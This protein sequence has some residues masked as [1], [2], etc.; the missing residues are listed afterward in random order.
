MSSL[1]AFEIS[2]PGKVILHGEHSVVYGKPAIAGP[3]GLRTYLTFTKLKQPEI[4]LEFASIP[5]TSSLSLESFNRFLSEYDCGANLAPLDFLQ[6]MKCT[7]TFVFQQYVT[8][9]PAADSTKERFALGTAL[10]MLNRV[11]QAE[12]IN[13]LPFGFRFTIKSVI[14]IGAGLGSSAG[15]GVCLSAGTFVLSQIVKQELNAANV[16]GF[17]LQND[18]VIMGKISQWGFD[19]EIV[20]HERPSGVDNTICTYGNLIKFTR[21]VPYETVTLRQR[22]RL[23]IVDTMVNRSTSKMVAN[24]FAMKEKHPQM[25]ESI[26]DAMGHLVNDAVSILEDET[27]RFKELCTLVSTNNNLLRAIGVSHPALEKVFQLAESAGFHVKLTGAGGGG[28][29]L[30]FLPD[31]YQTEPKFT[32]LTNDLRE[33]GFQCI[34]TTLGGEGVKFRM[35]E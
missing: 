29:A 34:E 10:Y 25:M 12:G 13:S 27:D 5:F 7:E 26:F 22:I 33:A 4:I 18:P 24:V 35:L 30:V 31:S 2:A 3:I 23:L 21:G 17:S 11:L 20:M 28:C 6:K 15:Y 8:T 32:E 14:S 19:S 9:Q 16:G 1:D